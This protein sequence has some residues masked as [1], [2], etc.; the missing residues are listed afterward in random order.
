[1]HFQI[2]KVILWPRRASFEPR[3]VSFAA[4]RVNIISGASKTGKSAI[5]PIIDYCLGSD[6]CAIPTGVIR[7]NCAWFGVV[8]ATDEG[9][10]LFARRNPGQQ[11]STG[12][13]FVLESDVVEIPRTI[14]GGNANVAAVKRRLDELAHL[15]N[16]ALDPE[17]VGQTFKSRPSFRDLMAFCFQP[18]NLVANQDVLFYKA[19]T[20]EHREKLRAV[21][22]YVLGAITPDLLAKRWELDSLRRELARKER[23]L[24][25]LNR[26]TTRWLAEL[27]TWVSKSREYGLLLEALAPDAPSG[28]TI[29]ALRLV[30]ARSSRDAVITA[31]TIDQSVGELV[32]LEREESSIAAELGGLK[33]RVSEMTRLRDVAGDYL[34]ALKVQRERLGLAEWLRTQ[35]TADGVCPVCSGTLAH[36]SQEL[37]QLCAA[38]AETEASAAHFKPAPEAFEKEFQVVRIQVRVVTERLNGIKVRKRA[39]VEK[40]EQARR[41][42][43]RGT[44]IDRFLGR[45]E[46]A[47][48]TY[49]EMAPGSDL[50]NEVA[51]LRERV[52]LLQTQVAEQDV[53]Q[54]EERALRQVSTFA[55]RIIPDL[56]A[57]RKNDAIWLSLSDLALKVTGG[58]GRED[59]LFEIGSGANWLS[60]HIAITLALQQFFISQGTNP[61]PGFL[62]Y[63]QPSQV[64]FPRRLAAPRAAA[65]AGGDDP[66]LADEDMDAVRKVFQVLGAATRA[67]S[68]K[69][70]VIILDHAGDQVWQGIDGVELTDEWRFG[71]KLVPPAW[72]EA[73]D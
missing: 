14:E 51:E 67:A 61:V 15:T 33:R 12:E 65:A 73:T 71:K 16:L 28:A 36:P 9:E 72:L 30:V 10:K 56:D 13:M 37:E 17:A 54:R 58:D 1:M 24:T 23:E 69:L 2:R 31:D 47:L 38:I 70:Q 11:Q 21:F 49:E 59:F 4:G 35:A 39:L 22:P 26:A 62:V 57:E 53:R 6:K 41:T 43:F 63:D 55:G 18:Q 25:S 52:R 32:T 3:Q 64:Y 66:E 7:D 8:V 34:D 50:V 48:A 45:L 68:G 19:D 5:I 60:Y 29:S 44:E 40:S 42:V 46:Q 20:Y 27:Q